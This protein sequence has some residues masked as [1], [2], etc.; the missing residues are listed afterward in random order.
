M[1]KSTKTIAIFFIFI[2]QSFL[3]AEEKLVLVGGLNESRIGQCSTDNCDDFTYLR[4]SNKLGNSIDS[5]DDDIIDDVLEFGWSGDPISHKEGGDNLKKKF[6]KWFYSNVCS[7]NEQ[8]NVSIIAH[9]WGSIIASDFIASLPQNTNIKIRTVVTYGSPVTGAQIKW[10]TNPFWETAISKVKQ[11]K[12][13]WINVVNKNDIIGWNIPGVLNYK[14]NGT[15]SYKKRLEELFPVS[16][17]ELDPKYLVT[18]AIRQCNPITSCA[19]LGSNLMQLWKASGFDKNNIPSTQE[20]WEVFFENTHFTES[21][22]PKRII[23]YIKNG[24]NESKVNFVFDGIEKKNSYYFP[25]GAKTQKIGNNFYRKY[26][27]KGKDHYLYTN[28]KYVYYHIGSG[29]KYFYTLEGWY[30][31]LNR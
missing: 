16:N 12:G 18:T 19:V 24:I 6:E 4:W 7:K 10:N 1:T 26:K 14:P 9:S 22:E 31:Y 29:W 23:N 21:Y 3:Y 15:V 2:L 11:M 17:S 30:N 13:K 28:N 20:G 8:C 5:L 25:K 27:V